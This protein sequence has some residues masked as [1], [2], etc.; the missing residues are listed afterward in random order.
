MSVTIGHASYMMQ[1]YHVLC[2]DSRTEDGELPHVHIGRY[3]SVAHNCTFVMSHHGVS[4]I[5]MT[6]SPVMLFMHGMGN[7]SSYCRGDINIGS[8][9]WIG[10]NVTIMDNIRIGHGAVVAA[11]AVVTRDVAPYAIVGGNPARVLR[12][13]FSEEQIKALMRICW[14]NSETPP[15]PEIFS[16]DI[17]AFIEAHKN[18]SVHRDDE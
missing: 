9:V 17:D 18:N 16:H 12:Y 5:A 7:N 15:G 3:C 6:N 14:W 11:G 8:D 10:A 4:R 1:P 13:R 2:Y